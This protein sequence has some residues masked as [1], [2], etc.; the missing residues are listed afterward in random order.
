MILRIEH[1]GIAVADE[2]AARDVFDRLLGKI[3]V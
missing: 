2:A 1:V 3:P